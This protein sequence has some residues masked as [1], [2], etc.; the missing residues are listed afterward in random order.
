MKHSYPPLL[1]LCYWLGPLFIILCHVGLILPLA[2]GL[3]PGAWGWGL[4]LYGIRMLAITGIYHRLLTHRA[5]H[6][7]AMVAWVG[8]LVAA[9]AGQMGPNWW[10][11][12]HVDHHQ[13][14]EQDRDP[15]SA[16]RGF[17]WAHCGWLLSSHFIPDK[18]PPDLEQDG[19]LRAIDR[20]HFLPM[21]GLAGLSFAIGGLDYLSAFIVSTV[22]LF[23]GVALVNSVC[24][25]FG[26]IPFATG[27]SSR[28]NWLVA[29]LT[30][31]EG[32]HNL[33]HALPWSV[34]QGITVVDGEIKYLPDPTFWFIQL[35]QTL[36]L[37]TQLRLPSASQ[38]LNMAQ[39]ETADS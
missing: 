22:L 19:V 30:L 14:V 10:K 28:N 1:L 7:P 33:H 2:T 37:A 21:L 24:H 32:W 8:S 25:K 15:H 16:A 26:S 34:R 29:S 11:G 38:T 5:Y 17:W 20:L 23:H 35:L 39:P 13:Y 3:S 36:G 18:L 27:D 9:S 6:A 31:G 12:H 4:L